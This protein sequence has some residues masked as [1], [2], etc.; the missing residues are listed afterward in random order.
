LLFVSLGGLFSCI[1]FLTLVLISAVRFRSLKKPRDNNVP[2]HPPATLLK[3]LCG[4]EPCLESNI[5]SFFRQDYPHFEIIF[6]ARHEY[7]PALAVV[8]Q[9]SRRHPD[10][11]V[12][13]VLS[14]EPDRPNAK[15]CALEKVVAAAKS[16][17]LVISD[18]DVHVGTN[19]LK[20]IICPLLDPHVGLVICLYRGVSTG[21]IW[22]CLEA[23]GMSVEMT[24]GVLVADMVEG[25]KFALGP[26]MATR[27]DV[28]EALG[29][30]G[31]WRIVVR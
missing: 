31:Y 13:I 27:F 3:P 19:Y 15:V 12:T 22:S 1:V 23:L 25:M 9:V 8:H 14:G 30:M 28:L 11:A 2:E 17:Y 24:S 18:S 6:G 29:G 7:D 5:E 26:T 10:V 16:D 21:G 20:E 4:L